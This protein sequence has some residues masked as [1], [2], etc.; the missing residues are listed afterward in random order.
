MEQHALP[1]SSPI[2]A[3]RHFSSRQTTQSSASDAY[4][5][6]VSPTHAATHAEL[7]L[8]SSRQPQHSA[9]SVDVRSD[10]KLNLVLGRQT[11]LLGTMEKAFDRAVLYD[12]DFD[13]AA[14]AALRAQRYER[15]K[16]QEALSRPRH[17]A[18]PIARPQPSPAGPSGVLAAYSEVWI[19]RERKAG[20]SQRPVN[21]SGHA[22]T[23]LR[24]NVESEYLRRAS[25][26]T[27]A[28][29]PTFTW[30]TP[31]TR[32]WA[33]P[34]RPTSPSA[35]LVDGEA[36]AGSPNSSTQRLAS[37]NPQATQ[38]YSRRIFNPV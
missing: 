20:A 36:R 38:A 31:S 9:T 10:P 33:F 5:R 35:P 11:K 17:Q 12:S 30:W 34:S 27:A 4:S 14:Q 32:P 16:R 15:F 8:A 22:G 1:N 13:N 26:V 24:A 25:G 29:P 28:F 21:E 6:P 7:L 2:R 3:S 37:N 23:A 19:P 18:R